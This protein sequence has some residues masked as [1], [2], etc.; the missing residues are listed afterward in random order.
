MQAG[1]SNEKRGQGGRVETHIWVGD[2]VLSLDRVG[3]ERERHCQLMKWPATLVPPGS[4]PLGTRAFSGLGLPTNRPEAPWSD[5]PPRAH[6]CFGSL[7]HREVQTG[8]VL[9]PGLTGAHRWLELQP[10]A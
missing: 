4:P 7:G 5:P 6:P 8:G 1:N 3:L 9:V 10:D 2:G